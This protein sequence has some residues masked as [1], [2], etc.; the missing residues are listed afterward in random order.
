ML[1]ILKQHFDP[2]QPFTPRSLLLSS[3]MTNTQVKSKE[4]KNNNNNEGYKVY[5]YTLNEIKKFNLLF[6][7]YFF[8]PLL[9]N[10]P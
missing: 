6:I 2:I 9:F 8:A 1:F 5:N 3:L 7:L 4:E 10:L